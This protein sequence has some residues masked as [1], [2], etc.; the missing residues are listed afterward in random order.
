MAR[1]A[2]Q[3]G[4]SQVPPGTGEKCASFRG[5]S[6][7]ARFHCIKACVRCRAWGGGSVTGC[8]RYASGCGTMNGQDRREKP[9]RRCGGDENHLLR[10]SFRPEQVS[11]RACGPR[12]SAPNGVNEQNA[13]RVLRARGDAQRCCMRRENAREFRAGARSGPPSAWR[14]TISSLSPG[15]LL[16]AGPNRCLAHG[17][18]G[19]RG[20]CW[21]HKQRSGPELYSTQSTRPRRST[22][23]IARYCV[24]Q[25]RRPQPDGPSRQKNCQ[26]GFEL[27]SVHGGWLPR[28]CEYDAHR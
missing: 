10:N 16:H 11:C 28:R 2:R 8:R 9:L 20:I 13:R 18:H 14:V 5:G 21:K 1:R 22:D 6:I 23:R 19:K 4:A 27:R 26:P 15:L 24:Q 7:E 3:D 17:L 25:R 12:S